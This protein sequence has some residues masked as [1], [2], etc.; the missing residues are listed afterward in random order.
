LRRRKDGSGVVRDPQGVR[1]AD[2]LQ[3]LV[4]DVLAG[5]P[6]AARVFVERGMGCVGCVFNR[7]E[8]VAEVAAVYA[9][10]AYQLACSLAEPCAAVTG[11]SGGSER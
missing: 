5:R 2:A 10:D 1:P 6:A 11:G 4:S 7:F 8:T 9:C 3:M